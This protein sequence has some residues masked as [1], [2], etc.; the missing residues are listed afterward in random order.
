MKIRHAVALTAAVP[1]FGAMLA[2]GVSTLPA[3]ASVSPYSVLSQTSK[4]VG[5]YNDTGVLIAPWPCYL[6]H[7]PDERSVYHP[8]TWQ[9]MVLPPQY[10]N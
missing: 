9:D 2:V 7:T 6:V 3:H 4:P 5:C 10:R 1:V 8:R